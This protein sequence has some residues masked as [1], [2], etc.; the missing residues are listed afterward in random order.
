MPSSLMISSRRLKLCP[1]GRSS[2]SSCGG[3]SSDL[4]RRFSHQ[5][6][7]NSRRRGLRNP[8]IVRTTCLLGTIE[9]RNDSHMRFAGWWE[10]PSHLSS[11]GVPGFDLWRICVH[12]PTVRLL[13]RHLRP[14]A[15]WLAV[16]ALVFH[17]AWLP[18]HLLTEAHCDTSPSHDH[19]QAHA[20][21]HGHSHAASDAHG[22]EG[23]ADH[24]YYA[25]DHESKFLSKRQAVLF[26][27]AL[28]AWQQ[29]VL[30][31][32]AVIVRLATPLAETA[33]PP[34]DFSPPSGP[35]APPLA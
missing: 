7:T 30:T 3:L 27:P 24:H 12:L 11:A 20:D 2:F 25:T 14:A 4:R 23:D 6:S 33:P 15:R 18:V 1:G 35:R 10:T 17:I 34:A 29:A 22:H 19:A 5:T 32:A 9:L 28:V 31:P 16:V 21:H 8:S 13:N 26:A